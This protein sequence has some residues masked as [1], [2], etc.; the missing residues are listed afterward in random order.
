MPRPYGGLLAM[1]AEVD[2][3]IDYMRAARN[4]SEHTVRAYATDIAQFVGFL[5]DEELSTCPGD[6]DSRT[7]RRYL[8]RLQKLG[9][10]KASTA[11]KLASLRAFFKYLL[12]KGLVESDPTTGLLSPK[13]DK[14]LPKFLRDEQVE[15][16][17]QRPDISE[18]IGMRDAAILEVLYATGARV[19]ELVGIDLHDL[20]LSAGEVKVLG[21]GSK[22]RIVLLGRAA[23][24]ALVT[25][26]S[27]GRGKL[28]S[29]R[30]DGE[31]ED[32]LFLNKD[33]CRLTTRSVG[34]LL[35]KHFGAVSDEMKISPHV[36]RHTFATHM[37]EHG[38]DLRAIQEL[39]GHASISTTQIYAHVSRERLK[40]VYDSAHPR[41]LEE[42]KS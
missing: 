2:R 30:R 14:R 15:A 10:S 31:S 17:M 28:L 32:A 23:C 20:D 13:L 38:A 34:R 41:A 4:P 40:Q 19:S 6:V 7:L 37:L 33:G 5:E 35:D 8:A 12:R 36:I 42:M 11:R 39:L 21:K 18:P 16:L 24:E 26:L 1:H 29:K 27:F 25:Y 9:M 3:F 22:E